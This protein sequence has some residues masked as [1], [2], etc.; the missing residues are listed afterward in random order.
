[1]TAASSDIR[2][3]SDPADG[4]IRHDSPDPVQRGITISADSATLMTPWSASSR[5]IHEHHE[6]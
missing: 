4:R 3:P 6:D 5:V 1:M 2:G